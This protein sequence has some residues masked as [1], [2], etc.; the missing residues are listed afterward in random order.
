MDRLRPGPGRFGYS[1]A[2]RST[3][4]LGLGPAS[5]P[6]LPQSIHP[7]MTL[8]PRCRKTV[9]VSISHPIAHRVLVAPT[10]GCRNV[11]PGTIRGDRRWTPVLFS[12]PR[13]PKALLSYLATDIGCCSTATVR[14]ALAIR[15][16]GSRGVSIPTTTSDGN[17]HSILVRVCQFGF[18]RRRPHPPLRTTRVVP[19]FFSSR[20]TAPGLPFQTRSTST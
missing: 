4:V 6:R 18:L 3:H 11:P 2:R 14:E 5:K 20:V 12:I 9:S 13:P 19:H 8:V 1:V 15:T 17:R 10:F 16:F 7:S